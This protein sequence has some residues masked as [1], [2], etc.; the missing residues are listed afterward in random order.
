MA[1]VVATPLERQFGQMDKLVT[2]T[3]RSVFGA[4]TIE[5]DFAPGVDADVAELAVQHA[6]N[7]ASP[8]LPRSLPAPPMY[9]KVAH[10]AP[11]LRVAL[12]SETL[13][14][15]E[16][17]R[18]AD[19]IIE[20]KL[21]QVSGV[22]LVTMCG[23]GRHE[24]HV[25]V[26][27][28]ALAARDKTIEDVVA[29]IKTPPESKS[30]DLGSA[31]FDF[32]PGPLARDVAK[33]EDAS[34][35]PD[36]I[37]FD[38]GKRAVVVTVRA[39]P[40]ADRAQVRARLESILSAIG[41]QLP[42]P[43]RVHELPDSLDGYELTGDP[44][45]SRQKRIEDAGYIADKLGS[46]SLVELGVDH[47]GD[48]SASTMVAS[49]AGAAH[50]A[51]VR[52]ASERSWDLHEP[53]EHVIGLEGAD[54]IQLRQVLGQHVA[55]LH[56]TSLAL[57]GTLGDDEQSTL[58]VRVDRDQMSRLGVTWDSV[59]Q[60][61]QA[62]GGNTATTIFTQLTTIP[63][64]VRVPEADAMK[65]YVRG[66]SGS[67]PLSTLVMLQRTFQPT[68]VYHQGQ[69]P[70]LGIRVAGSRA[71]LDAALAK[72]PLPAGVTRVVESPANAGRAA[73]P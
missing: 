50:A 19:E 36:C 63:V 54:E 12:A 43:I 31:G 60:A 32:V 64:M 57:H 72:I 51:L 2:M 20:Q 34:S 4:T 18:F 25:V 10:D 27:P 66:Q 65:L 56:G 7:D 17:G 23:T 68:V 73:P 6:I 26:D 9:S 49:I 47:D 53:G 16:I 22:G 8:L 69:F 67:V 24:W 55:A 44:Q 71:D 33:I 45:A 14:L 41:Q 58:D 70:W 13:R 61:L 37:A 21:A 46:A 5:L 39:Q 1:Q 52:A 42:A 35:E 29:E 11:V 3:S 30:L 15:D 38:A 62:I 28:V 40:G 59:D 48:L